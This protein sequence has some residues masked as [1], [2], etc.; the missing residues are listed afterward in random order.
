MN[1]RHHNNNFYQNSIINH[2]SNNNNN[3]RNKPKNRGRRSRA[4][5]KTRQTDLGLQI[6]FGDQWHEWSILEDQ[7]SYVTP[8]YISEKVAQLAQHYFGAKSH[9]CWDMFGGMG[10]DAVNFA[11]FFDVVLVTE[12]DPR[13]FECQSE[14]VSRFGMKGNIRAE[15][16]DCVQALENPSLVS[17]VDLVHFDPPWGDSFRTGQEFYFEDVY[18]TTTASQ[19]EVL[20]ETSGKVPIMELLDKVYQNVP[21]MILKSPIKCHSFERWAAS[22]KPP[23]RVLQ[24]CEF[25]THKLKYLYIDRAPAAHHSASSSAKIVSSPSLRRPRSRSNAE[26]TIKLRP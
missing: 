12:I 18:L 16:I 11:E 17:G 8:K 14:N 26:T 9:H 7:L 3:M 24:V 6:L 1:D 25:P 21:R 2:T 22:Q 15:C 13:I 4:K 5:V 10:M 20:S 23:A 19:G